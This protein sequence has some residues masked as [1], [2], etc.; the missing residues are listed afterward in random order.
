MSSYKLVHSL[1][2]TVFPQLKCRHLY[3]TFCKPYYN[4]TAE[5]VQA[6]SSP[7]LEHIFCIHFV[8]SNFFVCLYAFMRMGSL[9]FRLRYG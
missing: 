6:F 4:R 8:Q 7:F 1:L 9:I 5:N 3:C 2:A